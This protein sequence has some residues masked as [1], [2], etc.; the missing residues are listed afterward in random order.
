MGKLGFGDIVKMYGRWLLNWLFGVMRHVVIDAVV[1]FG[2]W[3]YVKKRRG[4]NDK[5]FAQEVAKVLAGIATFFGPVIGAWNGARA[6][7]PNIKINV[8]GLHWFAAWARTWGQTL[9]AM[10]RL[11]RAGRSTSINTSAAES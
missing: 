4:W 3:L 10:L 1:V 5:R 6:R 11:R 2:V 8:P 9:A 7:M